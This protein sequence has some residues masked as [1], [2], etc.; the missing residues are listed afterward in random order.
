MFDLAINTTLNQ[1]TLKV[2]AYPSTRL[3]LPQT[4]FPWACAICF[5]SGKEFSRFSLSRVGQHPLLLVGQVSY[6]WSLL[7]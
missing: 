2:A 7:G 1:K 4:L 6:M 5:F 3:E